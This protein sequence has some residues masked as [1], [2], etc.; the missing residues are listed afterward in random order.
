MARRRLIRLKQ[1]TFHQQESLL[2]S[3]PAFQRAEKASHLT[4]FFPLGSK[5]ALL[6]QHPEVSAF[7]G[8]LRD[9]PVRQKITLA[10]MGIAGVVLLLAFFA[11]FWF[12]AYTLR[13]RSAHELAVVG[14]ITAHNC[15]AAVMFKDEDAAAQILDGLKTMPQIVSAR[16]E[17]NDQQRLAFFG[18]AKEEA[19]IRTLGLRSGIRINGDRI[20]LAQPVKVNAKT[21]GT[22]YLLADLHA[23]TAQLLKLYAGSFALVLLASLVVAF[24]LSSQFLHFITDPILQLARTARRI[25]GNKDYS[26]RATKFCADEVGVLTDAFNQMLAQIQSQDSA[27]RQAEERYRGIFENAVVGIYQTTVEGR[28]LAANAAEA[29]IFGYD[30]VEELMASDLDLNRSCY[31]EPRRRKEFIDLVNKK[32]FVSRFE[33]AIWRKDGSIVWIAEEARALR[34]TTG[35]LIGFEGMNIDITERK[36]AEEESTLMHTT[37][38]AISESTD[39]KTALA[40]VLQNLCETTGWLL[41]QAWVPRADGSV[42][43]C[44][45]AWAQNDAAMEKFQRASEG[46]TFPRGV[47]LPGRIWASKQLAWIH[48]VTVD[49]NFPRAADAREAGLKAAVGI[50]VMTEE[51]VVAVLEFFVHDSRREDE[52]FVKLISSVVIQLGHVVQRKRLEES[53]RES[54]SKLTEAQHI[55]HLGHWERDLISGGIIWSDETYR[56]FGVSPEEKIIGFSRVE[57]LIHP[58]DRQKVLQAFTKATRGGARYDVEYRIVWPNNEVRFVH[59]QGDMIC[60]ESGQPRR[61][62]GT[63]HD[64][65]ERKRAEEALGRAEQKY[66]DMFENAIEGIFQTTP[67]GRYLSVNP[68]LARMYGYDSPEELT[69]TVTDIG[70]LI[71]V[72][73][74]RRIEFKRLIETHGFIEDFEYQVYRKDGRKIWLSENARAVRDGKGTVLYY[75]GAVQ[76]ITE[77]KRV[78]EV[79]RV[80]RAKSEFLSRMSHELRTPLNAILGFGQLLERQSAN[81][82]QRTRVRHILTAGRHLLDLINEILD[83][84]R[85]EAGRLQ[86][87][88]EPVRIADAIA[89]AVELMRPLAAE[90]QTTLSA[91]STPDQSVYVMA[92]RQRLKQVLLNLLTNGVKYTPRGGEVA[93]SFERSAPDSA[94][95]IVTDTGPGIPSDKISRLFTAFDRLGAEQSGVEGTGLGLALSQR[96]MQAMHGSIGVE[97][98]PGQGSR[99]WVELPCTKS[100]LERIAKTAGPEGARLS[101]RERTI[102]YVEDNLSNLTLIEQMLAEE[103]Q[104]TLIT[105]MQGRLALDLARQH[106][107]DLI[108]LDLHLPDMPGWEVLAELQRHNATRGIPV[109]VISA[110]A[111]SRQ[112]KRLMSAGARSY[113]TKPI[114]V[115]EFFHAI[116]TTGARN[117]K[118]PAEATTSNIAQPTQA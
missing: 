20:V 97:S 10:I 58:E 24:V 95:I 115:V 45:A 106:A 85:I 84:S 108:L 81:E 107:P 38:L 31:V 112:I 111:T 83:I 63:V 117:G 30:S 91:P 35:K 5:V 44:I 92:D 62:F 4:E 51:E 3:T 17:L 13:Q 113:L 40:A 87:S 80:S 94:R 18:A 59:S 48:D 52:R 64:I 93:I 99:F 75:E 37:T 32:G 1:N 105:A 39:F 55:A 68:A 26:V 41:G 34:D 76:D 103:P 101:G 98:T 12:E 60:D 54:E 69:R 14:D 73:P 15:A 78:D 70:K 22:L 21:E 36:R 6:A 74:E 2:T 9:R 71:Y 82:V 90:H 8:D 16:L 79:E 67:D 43:E 29:R 114:D 96:L 86:L 23:T 49:A 88:L 116:E 89:E 56:V 72:N 77:R 102:L 65:T 61:M 109:V 33:S 53:L 57:Q 11:L 110:D 42:L 7:I 25:A 118:A 19:D 66:R 50:P 27:L 28:Y 100:P 104:I 46:L 47:G